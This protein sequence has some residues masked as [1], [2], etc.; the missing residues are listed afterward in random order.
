[1]TH[2]D[3]DFWLRRA[4]AADGL[5]L[6]NDEER[7]KRFARAIARAEFGRFYWKEDSAERLRSVAAPAPRPKGNTVKVRKD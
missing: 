6:L 3:D 7:R 4:R 5:K 2:S 1:M